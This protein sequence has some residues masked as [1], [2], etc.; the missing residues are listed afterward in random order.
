M[1]EPDGAEE[2]EACA[3]ELD[4][5]RERRFRGS[6]TR[7]GP[8]PEILNFDLVGPRS[9]WANLQEPIPKDFEV[10]CEARKSGGFCLLQRVQ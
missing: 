1:S 9:L 2:F 8:K 4:S 7:R 3:R 10:P 5:S 6:Q